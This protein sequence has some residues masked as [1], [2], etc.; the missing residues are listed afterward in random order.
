MRP[1]VD[2]ARIWRLLEE[3]GRRARGPGRVYLTGGGSAILEGWRASTVAVDLKLDP[4]PIGIFEA[5]A[6]L[7][8]ELDLNV[9]LASPDQFLPPLPGW[10]SRSASL[11]GSGND[12][13][14]F[15]RRFW[16]VGGGR[17]VFYR[18]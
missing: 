16:E 6:Q 5:L 11:P 3:I 15:V 14:P 1:P 9:E 13:E 2:V 7:K 8:V 18:R 10:P 4:E 12:S 17:R